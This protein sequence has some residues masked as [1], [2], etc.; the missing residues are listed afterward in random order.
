MKSKNVIRINESQLKQMIS[1][2]IKKVLKEGKIENN[3][4]P[5]GGWHFYDEENGDFHIEEQ[6]PWYDNYMSHEASQ[7]RS[8]RYRKSCEGNERLWVDYIWDDKN[9]A[10][11]VLKNE[12]EKLK[13][14]VKE[15]P[16]IVQWQSAPNGKRISWNRD[17]ELWELLDGG[18]AIIVR[19]GK[20][21][22][23]GDV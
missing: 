9:E 8:D 17:L 12:Y 16:W 14:D 5:F 18:Y 21:E 4:I 6:D 22:I 2:S 23:W 7:K 1:E 3:R 11:K 20:E 19:V 13:Q 10:L 15:V